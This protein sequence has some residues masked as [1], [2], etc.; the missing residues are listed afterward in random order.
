MFKLLWFGITVQVDSSKL[1]SGGV[2]VCGI[3]F[4]GSDGLMSEAIKKKKVDESEFPAELGNILERDE[5]KLT[6]QDLIDKRA[7][8]AK[9]KLRKEIARKMLIKGIDCSKVVDCTG[10]T[11][12]EV[13]NIQTELN[14]P[15]VI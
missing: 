8:E 6:I 13:L 9:A 11:E 14:L 5:L 10:L 3:I 7:A 4:A 1:L 12:E 15:D 2:F